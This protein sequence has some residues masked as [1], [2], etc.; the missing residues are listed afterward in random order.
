MT[1]F[2]N[3]YCLAASFRYAKL[4][5]W[6]EYSVLY[7]L[8]TN[9]QLR[10]NMHACALVEACIFIAS[11]IKL[12]CFFL[13]RALRFCSKAAQNYCPR[14]RHR[15]GHRNGKKYIST[16]AGKLPHH[17][18]TSQLYI[19]R[20]L[21]T[22]TKFRTPS[23]PQDP[24]A[25][26]ALLDPYL[27]IDLR[28]EKAGFVGDVPD[29]QDI[30]N[31]QNIPLILEKARSCYP[32]SLDLLS[33]VG[34][35]QKRW[36]AV[37]W[38]IK[39]ILSLDADCPEGREDLNKLRAPSW[40]NVGI[41]LDD[42]TE[43]PVWA[44]DIL[45][46]MECA[47]FTLEKLVQ[48]EE[49]LNV[50]MKKGIGQ[51]WQ[52]LGSMI[53]QAADN[54]GEDS[55]SKLIMPHVF[56]ILAHMHHIN[57]LPG[58][59]YNYTQSRDP[60][61]LQRPPTLKL[62]SAQIMT[63]LSDA[64]WKV[65]D[66]EILSKAAMVGAK[67]D[68]KGHNLSGA[69]LQPH[70]RE[71]GISIWLDLILWSCVE[72]GLI[73][74]AAWI[75][76][77]IDR[78]KNHE[79]L[80]WSVMKWES[81]NKPEYPK[82]NWS[83]NMEQI[84]ARSR[85]NQIAGGIGIAG[86]GGEPSLIDMPPRT[87]SREVII[88]IIDGLANSSFKGNSP[89]V[90]Q[91]Y[92]STC[93]RLLATEGFGLEPYISNSIIVRLVDSGD[94][95]IM[96]TPKLVEQILR[97]SPGEIEAS[98]SRGGANREFHALGVTPSAVCLGL[99]HQ[100]LHSFAKFGNVQGALRTFLTLQNLIDNDRR[101]LIG[102]FIREVARQES[103]FDND[104]GFAGGADSVVFHSSI[105]IYILA[106][107]LDLITDAK[108]FDFG[109]WLL[110]SDD[111]D[112]STIPSKLYSEPILQP[113]LLRFAT[114]T[115][116]IQLQV[117]ITEKLK[118]PLPLRTLRVLLHCQITLGKWSCVKD[119]LVYLRDEPGMA[120]SP[121]DVMLIA[122]GVLQM[123]K[124]KS[125]PGFSQSESISEAVSLLQKFFS[126]EF[127]SLRNETHSGLR[128][129][130]QRMNQIFRMLKT[131]PGR[132]ARLTSPYIDI[133]GKAT[134]HISIP[135]SSFNALL[136]GV[137]ESN[138]S[139]AGKKLWDLWCRD[140]SGHGSTSLPDYSRYPSW[141]TS[142]RVVQPNLVTLQI[143]LRPIIQTGIQAEAARKQKLEDH[144]T[145]QQTMSRDYKKAFGYQNLRSR[146]IYETK[147]HEG[148][149]AANSSY[150]GIPE[151]EREILD[152]GQEM[153]ERFGLSS[154]EIGVEIP[155]CL[156][157]GKNSVKT[158]QL[159]ACY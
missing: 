142:Q 158:S 132:L 91:Q 138:G 117:K 116:D 24:N 130:V 2:H 100:N 11:P 5:L 63:I 94:V 79:Q 38:L 136:D 110:Y 108:L 151:E 121:L 67:N 141:E 36:K 59:I 87:I 34:V 111:V 157:P 98:M 107:F 103:R 58:S 54:L 148:N 88:A 109:R 84:I 146:N 89:K 25:W 21:A 150:L 80:S 20:S 27:P 37:I 154:E 155:W 40:P 124:D 76:T 127:N 13:P 66:S 70:V 3:Q 47:N 133:T 106:A 45:Q 119:L 64:A 14:C 39:A 147:Y 30:V 51:V 53:L 17:N 77:E 42:I 159:Q 44:D 28:S 65:H 137:V 101:E 71:L 48:T 125:K 134:A 33:Y 96:H 112:G 118:T 85:M 61:A 49:S 102:A 140:P 19:K 153:Y 55:D 93:K 6:R 56:Q 122:Q 69:S 7:Y 23:P 15:N 145:N 10:G 81:L 52:S 114:A 129:Q 156:Q 31:I 60:F 105:P 43:S 62:L 18:S 8:C 16:L 139:V 115:A 72:G 143:I 123:E 104:Y 4:R 9:D 50:G 29:G 57:N 22:K 78:R 90:I 128:S 12:S 82:A 99:L 83:L 75:A 126:G 144:G 32:H 1:P 120:W 26:A 131:C 149:V 73:T 86:H 41:G 152:W 35:H 135:T 97:L 95:D 113:A 46:P 74:E 92:L 68:Y